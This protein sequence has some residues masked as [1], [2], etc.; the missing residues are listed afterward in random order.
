M[1]EYWDRVCKLE[2]YGF[3]FSQDNTRILK[4]P[5]IGTHINM[6]EAQEIVSDAQDEINGLRRHITMLEEKLK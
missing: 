6:F 2:R 1:R 4:V 3:I 5:G